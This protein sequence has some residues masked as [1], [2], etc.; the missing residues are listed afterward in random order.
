[1]HADS[2]VELSESAAEL[3]PE[4]A[5]DSYSAVHVISVLSTPGGIPEERRRLPD[6]I[7][8]KA[9]STFLSVD[10]LLWAALSRAGLR[11]ASAVRRWTSKRALVGSNNAESHKTALELL[12]VP[13]YEQLQAFKTAIVASCE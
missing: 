10:P 6:D 5:V 3:S 13:V 9:I 1:M 7:W 8:L 12:R 4:A 11:F 2:I